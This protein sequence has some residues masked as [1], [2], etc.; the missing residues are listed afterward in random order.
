MGQMRVDRRTVLAAAIGSSALWVAG[1]ASARSG[2][3]A[4]FLYDDRFA[5]ARAL[6]RSARRHGLVVTGFSGDL[7][8]LWRDG[9]RLDQGNA[10]AIIGVT[11]PRAMLCLQQLSAD[12]GWRIGSV[13][14]VDSGGEALVRWVLAPRRGSDGRSA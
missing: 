8:R 2:A 3:P 13:R 1:A 9:L 4:R 14:N 6:A 5:A 11:T 12:H 7:T 10:G